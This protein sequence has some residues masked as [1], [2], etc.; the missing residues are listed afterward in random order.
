[1]ARRFA[2]PDLVDVLPLDPVEVPPRRAAAAR[3]R[4]R[5]LPDFSMRREKASP[6]ATTA[7]LKRRRASPIVCFFG[8]FGFFTRP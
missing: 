6:S 1:V 7:S 4:R 3:F 2:P 5:T 8:F